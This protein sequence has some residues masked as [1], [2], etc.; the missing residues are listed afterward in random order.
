[1]IVNVVDRVDV[2]ETVYVIDSVD[3]IDNVDV[4]HTTNGK[5]AVPYS[6]LSPVGVHAYSFCNGPIETSLRTRTIPML[7]VHFRNLA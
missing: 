1:L 2:M 6:R 3:V 4:I 7:F 5:L